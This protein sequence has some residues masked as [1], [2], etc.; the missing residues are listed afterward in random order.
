MA[1]EG[2]KKILRVG[3][4]QGGRIVEER[5]IR[6]REDVSLGTHAKNTFILPSSQLGKSYRLFEAKSDSYLLTF[7]ERMEGRLSVN[8]QV[9]DLSSLAKSGN[10]KKR[11]GRSQINLDDRSRGKVVI[12]EFTLLFQFVEKPP[13]LPRPQLPAAARGGL[14]QSVD[15]LMFNVLLLSFI[16]QAGMGIGLDVWWRSSGQYL[17][18][19]FGAKKTRAYEL[20]KAEVI[21]EKKEEEEEPEPEVNEEETDEA[22]DDTPEPEPEPKETV[23]KKAPKVEPKPAK[24]PQP[25][26]RSAARIKELKASVTKKTFLH[27]LGSIGEGD[28]PGNTLGAG[29]AS[30]TLDDAFNNLDGGVANAD[31]TTKT[32]VGQPQAVKSG[33]GAYKGLG[34]GEAGGSRIKTGAVKDKKK[35]RAEIKVKFRVRGGSVGG[36]SGSGRVDKGA[37]KKVFSRRSGA[38]KHCYEKALKSNPNVKGKVTIRFQ[39]GTAGRITRSKC[40]SNTTGSSAICQCILGK[41]KSWRFPSPEG[42]PVTFSYPFILSQG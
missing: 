39:I 7:D 30:S 3:I 18:T 12:G 35:K 36:Q 34:K 40:T 9:L 8:D 33:K 42:G 24:D 29:L 4:I 1:K 6:K 21:A 17:H 15:W 19:E 25:Q 27:A 38:I 16:V 32:F 26:K 10:T 28:G 11:G 23:K 31:G 37:V 2:A 14:S 13:V 5:L 20:L 22:E 41:V